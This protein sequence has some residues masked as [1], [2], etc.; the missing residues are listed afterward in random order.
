VGVSQLAAHHSH[1]NFVEPDAFL[2]E[3]W[4]PEKDEVFNK[5]RVAVLQPFSAGPRNCLGKKY[6]AYQFWHSVANAVSQF[7]IRRNEFDSSAAHI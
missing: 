7:G 6:V 4:L 2:P 5:D 1:I 3:R